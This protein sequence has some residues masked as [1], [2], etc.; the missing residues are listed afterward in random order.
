MSTLARIKMIF[1]SR[2]L[3]HTIFKFASSTWNG[4]SIAT[5]K[6]ETLKEFKEYYGK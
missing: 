3:L 6:Y 5:N 2:H 1:K 4:E